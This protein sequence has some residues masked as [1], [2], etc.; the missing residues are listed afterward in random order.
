MQLNTLENKSN[1]LI[2]ADSNVFISALLNP[3]GNIAKI[4]QAVFQG[5]ITLVVSE[6]QLL[7]LQNVLIYSGKFDKRFSR[8]AIESYIDIIESV[9]LQVDISNI[10]LPISCRDADDDYLLAMLVASSSEYLITGDKDLIVL[11]EHYKAII[12]PTDFINLY[13]NKVNQVKD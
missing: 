2:I 1:M 4:L 10:I 3:K 9:S 13:F 5:E 8:A 7:E 6:H 12:T 11:Q